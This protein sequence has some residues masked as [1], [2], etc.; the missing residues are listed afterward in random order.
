MLTAI[1]S[2]LTGIPVNHVEDEEC[3][4][5]R[6]ALSTEVDGVAMETYIDW[7]QSCYLITVTGLPTISVPCGFTPDGLPVGIQIV[8]RYGNEHGVLQLAWAFQ[9]ATQT[10]KIAPELS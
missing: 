5:A 9:Q 4:F 3:R 7:M 8:G 1:V 10:W 2:L 6:A